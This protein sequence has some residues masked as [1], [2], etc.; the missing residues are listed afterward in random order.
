MPDSEEQRW[1]EQ[2]ASAPSWARGIIVLAQLATAKLLF[3]F[4]MAVCAVLFAKDMGYIPDRRDAKLDVLSQQLS[5]NAESMASVSR[6]IE[7]QTEN[8]TRHAENT[9]DIAV[10]TKKLVR[11]LCWSSDMPKHE[12]ANKCSE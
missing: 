7:K 5:A 4:V 11:F 8:Q 10:S 1:Q 12:K 6:S 2:L 9:E 3:L